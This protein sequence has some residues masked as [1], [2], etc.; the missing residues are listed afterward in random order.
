M[1]MCSCP[2]PSSAPGGHTQHPGAGV[3]WT[4]GAGIFRAGV[5]LRLNDFS[6]IELGVLEAG[7]RAEYTLCR[8]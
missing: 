4:S 8:C 6:V 7:A 3:C 5:C 1:E 2:L